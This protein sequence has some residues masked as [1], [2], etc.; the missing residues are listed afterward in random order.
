MRTTDSRTA[1]A[2]K[3]ASLVLLVI[4]DCQNAFCKCPASEHISIHFELSNPP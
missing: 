4:P 2:R 1:D 3:A